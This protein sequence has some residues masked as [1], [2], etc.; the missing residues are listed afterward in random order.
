MIQAVQFPLEHSHLVFSPTA[1][2]TNGN[3]LSYNIAT[4][5]IFKFNVV[6]QHVIT[7][8]IV[9]HILQFIGVAD[10][11][12]LFRRNCSRVISFFEIPICQFR[13]TDGFVFCVVDSCSFLTVGKPY[14]HFAVGA[15]FNSFSACYRNIFHIFKRNIIAFHSNTGCIQRTTVDNIPGR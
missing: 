14:M 12:V 13:L 1:Q 8:Q 7:Q 5:I 15:H 10:K 4:V 11:H 2:T 9:F 3:K 6:R